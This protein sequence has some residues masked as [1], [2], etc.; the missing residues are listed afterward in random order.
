MSP[1]RLRE[2]FHRP[3]LAFTDGEEGIKGSMRSI[4]KVHARDLLET[5]DLAEPGTVL[6]YGGHAMA[7]GATIASDRLERLQGADS[8]SRGG[9]SLVDAD[10]LQGTW[11]TDGSLEAD[12]MTLDTGA[13][14]PRRRPMGSRLRGAHLRRRVR[15]CRS[16]PR[17]R[18][19]PATPTATRGWR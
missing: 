11:I 3:V 16:I 13:V 5:I 8:R 4:R 6:H 12:E 9:E 18:Q 1:R 19:A 14:H 7:A 15:S 17:R 2:R 10:D